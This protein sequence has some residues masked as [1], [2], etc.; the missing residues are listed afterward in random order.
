MIHRAMAAAGCTLE[1]LLCNL[2]IFLEK[3]KI[4]IVKAVIGL[5]VFGLGKPWQQTNEENRRSDGAPR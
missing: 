4:D 3:I 2:C 5:I 1:S